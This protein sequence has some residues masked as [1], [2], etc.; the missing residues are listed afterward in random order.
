MPNY[1]NGRIYKIVNDVDD[2]IYVG[3]TT[4]SLCR[5]MT[6]HRCDAKKGK[7]FKLYQHVRDI[8]IG[9]FRI[10]LI[11]KYP[12]DDREE[13]RKR[14]EHFIRQLNPQLN[15]FKAYQSLEERRQ[16][17]I[18]RSK[19]YQVENK[20]KIAKRSKQYYLDNKEKIDKQKKQY[21]IDNKVKI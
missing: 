19:Q 20:E 8:G 3:S 7:T 12:C 13:L 5:R 6:N 1:K 21:R 17:N 15:T 18:V 4:L 2:K 16:Y 11:E 14:E 9:H 10:V